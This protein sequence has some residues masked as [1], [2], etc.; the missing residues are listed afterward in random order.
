MK[1][2]EVTTH[3]A[4]QFFLRFLETAI[5]R[6]ADIL[7][8][9]G[10]AIEAQSQ[11]V[12]RNSKKTQKTLNF[13]QTLLNIGA[14]GDVCAKMR[15]S[16]TT[17]NRLVSYFG[18]NKNAALGESGALSMTALCAD[19][20]ALS[21]HVS[22]LSSQINFLLNATLG[23]INIHQSNT[24]KIFSIAAVIFLPPTLVAT[25]YGM[26]FTFMPAFL[27]MRFGFPFGLITMLLSAILPYQF[28]KWKKWL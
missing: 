6:I 4:A 23:M 3:D 21:D 15:E 24:I 17:F 27:Y 12:F 26:N 10:A 7:E 19:M 16:L 5:D 8:R 2:Q 25:V 28:F 20:Q 18:Q 22:F 1:K 9:I 13:Q 11:W 14:N